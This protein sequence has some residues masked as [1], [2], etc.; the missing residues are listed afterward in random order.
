VELADPGTRAPKEARQPR[1]L[2]AAPAANP[3]RGARHAAP[4]QGADNAGGLLQTPAHLTPADTRF[5]HS[6]APS[7]T[8]TKCKNP[9][10]C[11]G[12]QRQ[13]PYES[14]ALPLSYGPCRAL[15]DRFRFLFLITLAGMAAARRAWPKMRALSHVD[16]LA[17]QRKPGMYANGPGLRSPVGS[18]ADGRVIAAAAAE[19]RL[20]SPFLGIAVLLNSCQTVTRGIFCQFFRFFLY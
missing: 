7:D 19:K 4:V 14:L 17:L 2:T 11:Q 18:C 5:R 9:G 1:A 20:F 13:L 8:T 16:R 6:L 15:P 12:F 10:K 3:G